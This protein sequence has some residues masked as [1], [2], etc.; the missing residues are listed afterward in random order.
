[1]HVNDQ[2]SVA[3]NLVRIG[4]DHGERTWLRIPEYP[5]NLVRHSNG[6]LSALRYGYSVGTELGARALAGLTGSLLHVHGGHL[7]RM[8]LRTKL[9]YILHI[10]GSDVRGFDINGLPQARVSKGT[11]EAILR[12]A[13][14]IYSTPDLGPIV[15]AIRGDSSW[16][17]NPITPAPYGI[18]NGKFS[19]PFADLFF[20]HE[21]MDDKAL[22]VGLGLIDAIRTRSKKNLKVLG[23]SLGPRQ[24]LA[25]K[26]GIELVSPV[27]RAAH[28]KRLMNSRVVLSQGHGALYSL[29]DLEAIT[30]GANFVPVPLQAPA[31]LAYHELVGKEPVSSLDHTVEFAMSFL[32]EE[33]P[34][35]K[36]DLSAILAKHSDENVYRTMHDKYL[37]VDAT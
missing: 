29:N 9:P 13:G 7:W 10:H 18:A 26:N 31:R 17:P 4:K 37:T 16:L 34:T 2:A 12:A 25:Q 14:V 20:P 6:A 15:Q 36:L 30:I 33:R 11:K 27:S 8:C 23:L 21:W 32:D 22:E 5:V 28:Y 3:R 1:V 35:P 24:N 19:E